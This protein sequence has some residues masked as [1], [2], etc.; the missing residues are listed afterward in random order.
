MRGNDREHDLMGDHLEDRRDAEL[1]QA[2]KSHSKSEVWRFYHKTKTPPKGMVPG[3]DSQRSEIA[4][5]V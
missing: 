1:D 2:A 5:R 3:H 4:T